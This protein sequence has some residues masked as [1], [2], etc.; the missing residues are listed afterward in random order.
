MRNKTPRLSK[1]QLAVPK[2][3]ICRECKGAGKRL[4]GKR[5]KSSWIPWRRRGARAVLVPRGSLPCATCGGTGLRG[6]RPLGK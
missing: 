4:P 5:N 2:Q 3:H 1:K 6:K